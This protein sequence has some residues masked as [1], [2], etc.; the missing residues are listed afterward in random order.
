MNVFL[1]RLL[2]YLIVLLILIVLHVITDTHRFIMKNDY[3]DTKVQRTKHI[4]LDNTKKF[5]SP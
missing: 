4:A 2:H 5:N 3:F 1:V